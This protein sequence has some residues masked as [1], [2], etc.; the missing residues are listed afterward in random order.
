M[1]I[2]MSS[3]ISI[4]QHI[5]C[6]DSQGHAPAI[7]KVLTME[8]EVIIDSGDNMLFI[9]RAEFDEHA[10]VIV[11]MTIEQMT[12]GTWSLW[13]HPMKGTAPIVGHIAAID[14]H[15]VTID[16]PM[17]RDFIERA[18]MV[19]QGDFLAH[20][21]VVTA[22]AYRAIAPL[23]YPQVHLI[24]EVPSRSRDGIY[25]LRLVNRLQDNPSPDS[26]YPGT[27]IISNGAIGADGT[28]QSFFYG[29]VV[30]IDFD[31]IAQAWLADRKRGDLLGRCLM[32]SHLLSTRETAEHV[33]D[34]GHAWDA[35]TLFA[36]V[37]G[38]FAC[39]C[40][41]DE[42]RCTYAFHGHDC[43]CQCHKEEDA[44]P[45]VMVEG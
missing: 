12:V 24:A 15:F 44:I 21:Y 40:D 34:C 3:R 19:R 17:G 35:I 42:T 8:Q 13:Q 7:G 39:G 26:R 41:D 37:A 36:P 43:E 1:S 30:S 5:F 33:S 9:P 18:V 31:A 4:G 11:P 6:A 28:W 14:D 20:A 29:E 10:V 27:A 45:A 32:C 22:E 23:V 38:A 2:D 16:T 25:E